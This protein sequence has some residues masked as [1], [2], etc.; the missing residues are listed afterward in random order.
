MN[1]PAI[2]TVRLT[3]CLGVKQARD[4]QIEEAK[5][6][7]KLG[8]NGSGKSTIAKAL[9]TNADNPEDLASFE[10]LQKKTD[11]LQ[12]K[13]ESPFQKATVF[14]QDYVD[15]HLFKQSSLVEGGFELVLQTPEQKALEA[16]MK[17]LLVALVSKAHQPDV[18]EI[19]EKLDAVSSCVKAPTKDGSI[20]KASACYKSLGSG[21]ALES[22][23]ALTPDFSPYFEEGIQ[24][25]VEW[26]QWHVSHGIAY[27]ICPYC[28][29]KLDDD[30]LELV[31]KLNDILQS[32]DS[33]KLKQTL[34]SLHELSPLLRSDYIEA[35]NAACSSTEGFGDS[36]GEKL[37]ELSD[38]CTILHNKLIGLA[39]CQELVRA[40]CAMNDAVGERFKARFI[41]EEDCDFLND[42]ARQT[43]QP[44]LKACSQLREKLDEVN[45]L[46][47]KLRRMYEH[48]VAVHEG[49]IN[50]FLR[51]INCPYAIRI[52]RES[53]SALS[54]YPM[55]DGSLAHQSVGNPSSALSQGEKNVVSLLLFMYTATRSNENYDLII[56]DDPV[57]S[58]DAGKRSAILRTLFSDPANG[59]AGVNE[60]FFGRTVLMLTHDF[61]F[62]METVLLAK[63]L[64]KPK[65]HYVWKDANGN[66]QEQRIQ[67][68][69]DFS[70]KRGLMYF[71]ALQLSKARN[72]KKDIVLRL[73]ALRRLLEV[74]G[75]AH[76]TNPEGEESDYFL[77]F[78]IISNIFHKSDIPML[79]KKNEPERMF[80]GFPGR[81]ANSEFDR[82]LS[83][84][85][86][87][88]Q[89]GSSEKLSHQELLNKVSKENLK[90][91]YDN[92]ANDFERLQIC[93]IAL[94][95][96]DAVLREPIM[97]GFLDE[98]VHVSGDYLYQLDPDEYN[99]VSPHA[100]AWCNNEMAKL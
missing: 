35:I 93:R 34:S 11:D 77:A 92:C 94:E 90:A 91:I 29:I 67:F 58:F 38:K 41:T 71:E 74:Q 31:E 8:L 4:I 16:E 65:A 61:P 20:S 45:R 82:A 89:F 54:L 17:T 83:A 96:T 23:Q 14:N 22:A 78:E 95:G 49:E 40:S 99:V 32:S 57:S 28:G 70:Q 55:L 7:V 36:E 24:Q 97:A 13:V 88:L 48:I 27:G 98:S 12:P 15:Q 10:Y 50:R 25:S 68:V 62:L 53:G 6:N 21:N 9:S 5:L 64:G 100:I 43:L 75:Y 87:L 76:I 19:A 79:R 81:D 3:N 63:D 18:T 33:K 80:D 26:A 52:S 84:I 2:K 42:E 37:A 73:A 56:L 47:E 60:N 66:L 51:N 1:N 46:G 86:R 30:R 44:T 69:R 59:S 39:N 85:E 72:E